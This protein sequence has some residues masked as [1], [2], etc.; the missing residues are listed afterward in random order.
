MSKE[1]KKGLALICW[2]MAGA[3]ASIGINNPYPVALALAIGSV[4]ILISIACE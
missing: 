4:A 3:F 1:Q 2:I